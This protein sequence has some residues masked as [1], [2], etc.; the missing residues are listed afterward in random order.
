[1]TAVARR[2]ERITM[3]EIR[4]SGCTDRDRHA[5]AKNRLVAAQEYVPRRRLRRA[6][7]ELHLA[8]FSRSRRCPQGESP[9]VLRLGLV[10]S[11]RCHEWTQSFFSLQNSGYAGFCSQSWVSQSATKRFHSARSSG[12]TTTNYFWKYESN[13][14]Q[15]RA[16]FFSHTTFQTES[17]FMRMVN[18]IQLENRSMTSSWETE[19]MPNDVQPVREKSRTT[20]RTSVQG[21]GASWGE[22]SNAH[23]ISGRCDDLAKKMTLFFQRSGHL[24]FPRCRHHINRSFAD[25]IWKNIHAQRCWHRWLCHG[26]NCV[27]IAGI[28]YD[29]EHFF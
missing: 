2:T 4:T 3:A 7:V 8:D 20:Q 12:A 11:D 14:R 1:M 18:D 28:K 27:A 5:V 19:T 21:S 9:C 25:V 13:S 24:V 22:I 23:S 10:R 17:F 6:K 26:I 29:K 16:I 15:R